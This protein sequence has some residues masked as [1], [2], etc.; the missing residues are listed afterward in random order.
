MLGTL[1]EL[2][3][4]KMQSLETFSWDMPTGVLRDVFMALHDLKG[5]IKNVHVRFHDNR[6]TTTP[7][8]Q[9]PSRRVETPTF[10][11]F[12]GLR[13]LSVLDVD[14]KQYL[15]EISYA[16]AQS[17]DR[18]K[19]LRI[20]LASH[21][22]DGGHRRWIRDWDDLEDTAA[23]TNEDEPLGG[24]LGIVVGRVVNLKAGRR[25]RR[26]NKPTAMQSS[27]M[28]MANAAVETA[29]AVVM[30]SAAPSAVYLNPSDVIPV[31]HG[32]ENVSANIT[33]LPNLPDFAGSQAQVVQSGIVAIEGSN[34]Q[35]DQINV[36]HTSTVD[37]MLVGPAPSMVTVPTNDIASPSP[38]S[39]FTSPPSPSPKITQKLEPDDSKA[40]VQLKLETLELE[41][42]P[43]SVWVLTKAID[44]TVLSNLT[45]LNCYNHEKLWKA[46]RRKYAP[47]GFSSSDSPFNV[48]ASHKHT[49]LHNH[50]GSAHRS[51][52]M[53]AAGPLDYKIRLK[54]LH[55]DCVTPHLIAFIRDTLPPNSLEVLFLQETVNQSTVT[56]ENIYKGALRRHKGSLKKLLVDSKNSEDTDSVVKWMFAREHIAFAS[57]GKMPNLRELACAI[58][59]KDWVRLSPNILKH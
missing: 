49:A 23:A 44:W 36:P 56:M 46:L 22:V 35:A 28:E 20:G 33:S 15:E 8:S 32:D 10:R 47:T 26:G 57:S 38:A 2:A 18:L 53:D 55:T 17:V 41:R 34:T 37:L 59:Y 31:P 24:V 3:I 19:E 43:I 51:R 5:T 25:H 16:V 13:S 12:E 40:P 21:I 54:K 48:S 11:G 42:V 45:I 9:D 50:H 52:G 4:T 14:E 6:E 7:T 29:E 58:D 39:V 30:T 1:V 27:P